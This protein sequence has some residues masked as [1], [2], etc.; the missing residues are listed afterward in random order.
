MDRVPAL[1][2]AHEGLDLA[3]PGFCKELLKTLT[4]VQADRST[5]HS[6]LAEDTRLL[7]RRQRATEYL[8]LPDWN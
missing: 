8:H 6:L 2:Q 5:R 1:Q 3:R 7:V 4:F